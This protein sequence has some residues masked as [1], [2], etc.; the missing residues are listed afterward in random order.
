[1]KILYIS[2]ARIPTEKAHGI[3]IMKTCEAFAK[4]G[5]DVTL[6]IPKRLNH[7]KD[8]PFSFYDVDRIFKI[9]KTYTVDVVRFGKCGFLTQIISFSLCAM[10]YPLFQKHD[11]VYSRDEMPLSFAAL[12][13]KNILYEA[14]MPRLNMFTKRF[15]RMVVISSGLKDFY[16]EQGMKTENILVAHDAVDLE[17]FDVEI[18]K[19]DIRKKLGIPVDAK[20]AMYIG[21]LD[22]WKGVETLL[23]ASELMDDIQVVVVGEGELQDYLKITYKKALFLGPLPYRD[24]AKNQRAA[25]VLVIPNS[26]ESKISTLYTSPLKVFAHMASEVPIVASDLPSLREV[27]HENNSTLVESDNP[28]AFVEGIRLALNKDGKRAKMDVQAFT[29]IKR[30]E[31]IVV[32]SNI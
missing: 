23:K 14:H 8:D 21:R 31:S 20:V 1:M 4:L 28:V 16:T 19:N 2:N 6:L 18:N 10:W 7:I 29:W 27:L 26:K 32:F 17:E 3:Q 5:H 15:K 24:L 22:K 13:N 25:D 12:F 9:K 11:L 30:T